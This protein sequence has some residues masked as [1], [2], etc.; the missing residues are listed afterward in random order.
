MRF[1]TFLALTLALAAQTKMPVQPKDYGQFETLLPPAL[2]PDGQWLAYGINRS[3]RD[4]ELRITAIAGGATKTAAFGAQ[5]VFSSDSKWA[6]YSIGMSESAEEKLKKDKKPVQKKL[7]LLNLASGEQTAIDGVESFAFSPNGAWLAFRRYPPEKPEK[8]PDATEPS[9][10]DAA[11]GATLIV[12]QLS[13]GRDTTF[14]NVSEYAWQNTPKQGRLLAI[15]ISAED[16]T[17]N[18]VQLYDPQTGS[19]RVLDSS[20]AVYSGLSWRKKSADLA[21]LKAKTDDAHEGANQIA[22]AWVHLTEPSEAAHVYDPAKDARF[23]AGM[24]LVSY[25]KPAWEEDGG[26][27]FLGIAK[28]DKKLP[29]KKDKDKKDEEEEQAAVDVWHWRDIEVQ[30]KQKLS[31]KT[32]RQKNML[33]A[34]N[35]EQ[36]QFVQLGHCLTEQVHP[37]KHQHVAYAAD[38]TAY[39]MERSIGRP[40]ADLYLVDES[41]GARTKIQDKVLDDYHLE[42]S[43]AGKYLTFYQAD[44]YWTVDTASHSI[45]NIT[46][47]VQASFVDRESD[48]TGNQ[49]PPFG[50][51][52]WTKN[53]AAVILYDK[54]DLW[55]IA[56][57]GSQATRLTDG[58]ADQVRHRLVTLD[59]E[60]ESID[61]TKP[62]YVSLFGIYTKKSGY[63]RLTAGKEGQLI[64]ADKQ[65][66]R[67]TKAKDADV[68]AY[69]SETF[70]ESPNAYV[71]GP[72]LKQPRQITHTNP[73]Q[74]NYAW[75]H[76]ELVEYKNDK[77]ERLQATLYYPAGYEAGKKYPM[78][79]YMYEK[80]SD[81]LHRY[82]APSERDYYNPG[83]I[84]SH[85]YLLLMPDIIFRPREPGLSVQECV[86]AAVK[87]VIA[88]GVVDPKKVGIMGHSWGGFDTTFLATHS[89]LFAAGVAGAP[90]TDLVSNYGN[91]HWSSGIAETD[92]I[93]TGQQR[94]QVPLYDDLDAYIRNS[95]V[96]NVKNM[97][98]ALMIEVGDSDGTVFYH[99]GVELYNI[100][101]RAGKDVV[102]L[103]YAGEDHGL[104]KKQDQMDYQ[105][106]IFAWFGHYLKDE[107]APPWMADGESYLDREREV[108]E[109]KAAGTK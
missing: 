30:P 61:T 100:A 92:H 33:A 48:Q 25:H 15:A 45:V 85:G 62:V 42:A 58:A 51:A 108:K 29:T 13:T 74:G 50:V 2:S 70:E 49:K 91:H 79:V 106:R 46:K 3:S 64:L 78:I 18:G 36:G 6:A 86:G 31:A 87:K 26:V 52:G 57:N 101:R 35:L 23:P 84:T 103:V 21:V 4:N 75:G 90:I 9:D 81:G 63:A 37:L 102:L 93:E 40:E 1:I 97:T 109:L 98:T 95:A 17:G 16:K 53:D 99:Q 104:R 80:L 73:F 12:R 27:V 77:G 88:M 34:W 8:K 72:D 67:L 96:F 14:G 56:P 82:S 39:A 38:W 19:L 71:A 41:T 89:D 28:W 66:Q 69:V 11:P 94:M 32:N 76:N 5:A 43:P 60:E 7:G 54:F 24:R 83:A 105:R 47:N 10:D 20:S 22:L 55:E 59:P 68:L 107:P 44:H 65:I